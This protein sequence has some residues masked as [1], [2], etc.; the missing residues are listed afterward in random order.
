MKKPTEIEFKYR[1]D[2]ISLKDF[3]A[4][5]EA[6]GPLRAVNPCGYDYFYDNAK[7]QDAFCR[8][9]V[10][11]DINQLTFKRKTTDAN[12]FIRTEHNMDLVKAT[13]EQV[14]S[15]VSEFGYAHNFS[16]YK[17]CF[18]YSYDNYTLVYY[19]C[20]DEDMK[21][22]GRF[23]EIEMKE[24]FQWKSEQEA[25][26]CLLVF[27]KLCKPLGISPQHRIKR[28]LFELYRK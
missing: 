25:W 3:I 26:D 19:V 2:D 24:D 15:L 13:R 11:L 21:E 17:N 28:S 16:L 4:F 1:A 22:L 5:C 10:G 14:R 27:E 7:D 23:I 20:Y 8:H 6:R 18:V 9:R 12:N